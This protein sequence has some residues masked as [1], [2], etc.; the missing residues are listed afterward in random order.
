MDITDAV[1]AGENTLSIKVVN[2]WPNRLIGDQQPG[3]EKITFAPGSTYKANSP[4][5]PSGL[6]GPVQVNWLVEI[7]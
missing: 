2:L 3:A 6:I 7:K 5:M 1:K 4:L